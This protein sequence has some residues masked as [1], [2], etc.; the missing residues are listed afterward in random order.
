[1]RWAK[2][3][4]NRALIAVETDI[5]T[6]TEMLQHFLTCYDAAKVRVETLKEEKSDLLAA[7]EILGG[8]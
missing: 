1:M 5:E 3:R 4:L 6:E 7:I 2:A 8:K